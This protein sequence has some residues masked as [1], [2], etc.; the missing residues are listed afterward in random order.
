V[1]DMAMG[2]SFAC[3][4]TSTNVLCWGDNSNRQLGQGGTSTTDILTPVPVMGLGAVDELEAG[5]LHACVRIGG[6]VQCWGNNSDFQTGESTTTTDQSLPVPVPN[7]F[8]VVDIELGEGHC[9]ALRATGGVSCWGNDFNGQ[10]GDNDGDP[11]DPLAPVDVTGLP[12][13]VA[14]TQIAA[15]HDHNCALA[16]GQ[17]YCWGEGQFGQLGQGTE[18]DSDTALLVPGLAGIVQIAT[19]WDYNCAIDGAGAM[20]CWGQSIDGQLGDGGRPVTGLTE[21]RSPTPFLV[22]TGIT[23][24]EVGN[25]IT[26]IETAAGWSCLGRRSV[27][28][29]GNG[30][31]VGP[32]FPV[33]TMFGP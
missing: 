17:V 24:V 18:T 12:P 15:G 3:V 31:T 10:M 11:A 27:G 9:C 33:A 21:V 16:G 7:L 30:T 20:W 6:S 32:A 1:Q 22:A 2:D 5:A 8:D 23:D 14:V 29:L 25:S 26:C 28:Q 19:S 4:A 13:G